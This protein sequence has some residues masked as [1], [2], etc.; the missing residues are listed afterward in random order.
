MLNEILDLRGSGLLDSAG[1]AYGVLE[2]LESKILPDWKEHGKTILAD[3]GLGEDTLRMMGMKVP[4]M[5]RLYQ[6]IYAFSFGFAEMLRDAVFE[7]R[8]EEQGKLLLSVL[9]LHSTLLSEALNMTHHDLLGEMF[10]K[11]E[12]EISDLRRDKLGLERRLTS[13]EDEIAWAHEQA[14]IAQTALEA[15]NKKA[16]RDVAEANKRARAAERG[17]F[18]AETAQAAAEEARDKAL[19]EASALSE[20]VAWL[21]KEN[22]RL[23]AGWDKEKRERAAENTAAAKAAEVI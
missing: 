14:A 5:E 8:R 15:A 4:E 10:A 22:A 18:D 11:K 21:Q 20:R 12:F 2:G 6:L 19:A 13:V 17:Q 7:R 1:L 3:R 23:V 9:G 16:E